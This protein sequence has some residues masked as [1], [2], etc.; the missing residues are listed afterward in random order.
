[1]YKHT[2][3]DIEKGNDFVQQI[4]IDV[5]STYNENVLGKHGNFGGQFKYRN[6]TL[7][8]S[9]DGVGTKGILI[10]EKTGS[11]YNCGHDIVNHSIN[12][13]L[14]QG[15]TPLFFLDYIASSKLNI[16]D[17]ASFVKGCCDACKES[18][19]VVLG[20]ET[21]EMP[22]V[23]Q[24]GHMDMVGT[25]V[26]DKAISIDPDGVEEFDM[27]IGF[28]SSG[29]QTNGYTLIRKILETNEP[30]E[31]IMNDFLTPHSSFL[32][33]VLE[34]SN[35][36][37][38]TGMCHITGGGLTENLKRVIPKGLELPLDNNIVQY[39][40]WC[41]WLQQTGNI[42]NEEMYKVFNCGIGFIVFFRPKV[43]KAITT[44]GT[45]LGSVKS[46]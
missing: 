13:I 18:G 37:T 29:P 33:D 27:A 34:L 35:Y 2:G 12:D 7:V 1:M 19:C 20:G 40:E 38:I 45:Y 11:Y 8:A 23:Y 26:G 24:D 17:S 15:A 28:K 32:Q 16:E 36:C 41:K 4:K 10:K 43:T 39:P 44:N 5:E 30:P 42:S 25:I 46:K 22:S 3:V 21:A 31:E 9:T 14:V 6:G